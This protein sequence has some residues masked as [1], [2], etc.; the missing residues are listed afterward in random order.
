MA[1]KFNVGLFLLV[2]LGGAT[3][4]L[5]PHPE[6]IE[7]GLREYLVIGIGSVLLPGLVVF[8]RDL[9]GTKPHFLAP[10]VTRFSLNPAEIFRFSM[11]LAYL[12]LAFGGTACTSVLVFEGLS[13]NG[14]D[15]SFPAPFFIFGLG[16]LF[17]VQIWSW[18][19]KD[20]ISARD[21]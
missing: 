12:C 10:D 19:Y 11:F 1:L 20:R 17:G 9:W 21:I 14:I 4:G 7:F 13:G 2:T 6:N 5:L 16:S 18:K 15:M 8:W 3:F